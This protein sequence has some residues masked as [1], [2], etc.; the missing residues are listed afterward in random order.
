MLEY[1]MLQQCD[2]VYLGLRRP[3]QAPCCAWNYTSDEI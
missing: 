2:V 3:M 1:I